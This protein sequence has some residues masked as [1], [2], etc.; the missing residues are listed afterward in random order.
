MKILT[1]MAFIGIQTLSKR[2][3]TL[4]K[5]FAKP[6]QTLC[7]PFANSFQTLYKLL[8]NALQTPFKRLTNSF[9]TLSN[10]LQTLGKCLANTVSWRLKRRLA[11]IEMFDKTCFPMEGHILSL[12]LHFPFNSGH[13]ISLDRIFATRICI[14]VSL[15]NRTPEF[16]LPLTKICRLHVSFYRKTH[17]IFVLKC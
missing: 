13:E 11:Q 8:V 1:K 10:A 5:P 14:F 16:S 7:K 9:Q 2:F 17:C 4:C 3:Q 6:R 12:M 15:N